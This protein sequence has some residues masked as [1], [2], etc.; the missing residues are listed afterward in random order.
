MRLD[1]STLEGV[2]S[3]GI[4]PVIVLI[5]LEQGELKVRSESLGWVPDETIVDQEDTLFEIEEIRNRSKRMTII[6]TKAMKKCR[7]PRQ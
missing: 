5:T 1:E 2:Y 3:E 6:Q 7:R 4:Q